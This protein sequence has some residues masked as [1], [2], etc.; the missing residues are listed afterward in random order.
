MSIRGTV[1]FN[2]AHEL[3]ID[4]SASILAYNKQTEHCLNK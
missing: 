2:I 1:C 3:F 4:N